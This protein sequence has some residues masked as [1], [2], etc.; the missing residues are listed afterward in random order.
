MDIREAEI[1]ELLKLCETY[2]KDLDGVSDEEKQTLVLGISKTGKVVDLPK[3]ASGE[4]QEVETAEKLIIC[5]YCDKLVSEQMRE[6][7]D[8]LHYIYSAKP[9]TA[10]LDP[11]HNYLKVASEK[12]RDTELILKGKGD[13]TLYESVGS[14]LEGIPE[15]IKILRE[16][17]SKFLASYAGSAACT[18]AFMNN[19]FSKD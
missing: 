8:V 5:M 11:D 16:E 4:Q 10:Y 3:I 6:F 13:G 7:L 2:A 1:K 19:L 15:M 9:L 17:S 14:Y 12:L 18:A